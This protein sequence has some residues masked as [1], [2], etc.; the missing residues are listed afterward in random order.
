MINQNFSETIT[1]E[2]ARPLN[3]PL[4]AHD[5]RKHVIKAGKEEC[6]K[7]AK[8]LNLESLHDFIVTLEID[9]TQS[10]HIFC[11]TGHLQA[12][13]GYTCVVTLSSFE[14]K[15]DESIAFE[16]LSP[17]VRKNTM[18]NEMIADEFL[19]DQEYMDEEGILDVG[20]ISTQYLSLSLDPYPRNPGLEGAFDRE[21]S[22]ISSSSS[23]HRPFD[24]LNSLLTPEK[25]NV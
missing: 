10:P 25:E 13:V 9:T 4:L 2:F 12:Q 24:D 19:L 1:P 3:I 22:L 15:I 23:M 8:R 16:V 5:S 11:V 20:E 18:E 14:A 6:Q 17:S 21:E 7:L